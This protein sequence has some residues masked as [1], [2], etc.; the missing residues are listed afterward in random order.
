MF[1]SIVWAP[2]AVTAPASERSF[3]LAPAFRV[4]E[5]SASMDP[6]RT[7]P[8]P[9]VAELPTCQKMLAACAP[10]IRITLQLPVISVSVDAGI[11]KTQTAFESPW[12]S[13]VRVPEV[14]SNELAPD[15]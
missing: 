15:I 8:P 7:H 3:T 11:W 14:I 13:R 4:I 5:V 10:L 12:A 9:I 1:E 2:V 6:S